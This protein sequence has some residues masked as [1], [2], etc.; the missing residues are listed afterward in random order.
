V[1]QALD[2]RTEAE[3]E[4]D[5]VQTENFHTNVVMK[6]MKLSHRDRVDAFNQALASEPAHNAIPKVGPG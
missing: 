4:F 2:T 5:R 6:R 3:I 1:E